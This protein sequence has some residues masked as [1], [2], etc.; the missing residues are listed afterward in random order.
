MIEDKY[1]CT[2]CRWAS[3]YETIPK[4]N[5]KCEF[6]YPDIVTF[7]SYKDARKSYFAK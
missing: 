6:Y 3:A 4:D 5:K 7:K 2:T 1:N